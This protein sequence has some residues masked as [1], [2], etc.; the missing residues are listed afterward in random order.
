ML[1]MAEESKLRDAADAARGVLESTPVYQDAVQPGARQVGKA[2][3]TVGK[4]V[5]VALAPVAALVWGYEKICTWLAPA[6]EA[7]LLSIS[8]DQIVTPRAM[9]AGP[10]IEALRFAGGEESLRELYANLLATAMD[11][12]TAHNAHPAFVEIIKQLSPDEAKL[13]SHIAHVPSHQRGFVDVH[14]AATQGG[15][16]TFLTHFSILGESAECA[17]PDL[18]ASY[19]ENLARLGIVELQSGTWWTNEKAG[20]TYERITAHARVCELV[21]R[22]EAMERY[23]PAIE[24][25][26]IEITTLG[27]QFIESCVRDR[28][29]EIAA[30]E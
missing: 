14:A 22:I 23:T 18:T 10:A 27:H 8:P 7:R 21:T 3:E 20:P 26:A 12:D 9:I 6:L 13:L 4:A 1:G 28:S 25:G 29:H 24:K 16:T 17:Y 15:K 11:S 19:L 5:N 2:L 30:S